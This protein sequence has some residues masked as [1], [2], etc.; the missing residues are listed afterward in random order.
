MQREERPFGKVTNIDLM[1]ASPQKK[2]LAL[3]SDNE[4]L[5]SYI[6]YM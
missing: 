6:I 2:N 4:I 3:S 1:F 5:Y